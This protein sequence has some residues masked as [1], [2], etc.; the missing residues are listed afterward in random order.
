MRAYDEMVDFIAAGPSSRNVVMF[1][2]SEEARSRVA[3]LIRREKGEG[4]SSEETSELEHYQQLEHLMRLA[5]A[6]AT[7]YLASE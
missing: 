2:P 3:D 1:R 4:L 6:R 5:K 7:R